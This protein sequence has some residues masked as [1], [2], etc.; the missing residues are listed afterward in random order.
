MDGV[1][2]YH[3]MKSSNVERIWVGFIGLVGNN[4]IN[5][6][7]S[8]LDHM[9]LGQLSQSVNHSRVKVGHDTHTL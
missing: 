1:D 8:I 2:V 7:L 5:M 3:G 9:N 4:T 6:G